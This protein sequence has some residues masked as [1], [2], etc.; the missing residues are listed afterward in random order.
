MKQK[1][2]IRME[3]PEG[4]KVNKQEKA[5]GNGV[6]FLVHHLGEGPH[7]PENEEGVVYRKD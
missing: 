3:V 5:E 2:G 1:P 4:R 7:Y 6:P